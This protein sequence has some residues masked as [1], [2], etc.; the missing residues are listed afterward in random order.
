[1]MQQNALTTYREYRTGNK[2]KIYPTEYN[3]VSEIIPAP[4]FQTN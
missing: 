4:K 2:Y 3:D 1:M